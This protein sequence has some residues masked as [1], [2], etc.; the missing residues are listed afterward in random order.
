MAT[1]G[2][3]SFLE[4][5]LPLAPEPNACRGIGLD[6]T[7]AGS[8]TDERV[9]WLVRAESGVETPLVWP[10]EWQARFAPSLEVVDPRGIVRFRQGDHFT[11]ACVKGPPEA[12]HSVLMLDVISLVVE[13]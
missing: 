6:A 13:Q 11:A 9:T 8:A 12:L 5:P 3:C 7:L 2:G 10:P 4:H 1:I